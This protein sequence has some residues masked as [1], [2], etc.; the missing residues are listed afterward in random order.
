M[1]HAMCSAKVSFDSKKN[2]YNVIFPK[3]EF[4]YDVNVI[5]HA[6]DDS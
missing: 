6:V 2:R 5:L 4:H 3:S 1:M